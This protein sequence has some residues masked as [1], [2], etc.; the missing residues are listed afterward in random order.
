MDDGKGRQSVAASS[1][2]PNSDDRSR[3]VVQENNGILSHLVVSIREELPEP[4]LVAPLLDGM[5]YDS[6]YE[7]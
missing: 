1:G 2:N 7:S 3:S 4:N 5:E 6:G